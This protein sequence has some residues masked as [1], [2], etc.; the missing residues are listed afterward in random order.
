MPP[1]EIIWVVLTK[2]Q[3]FHAPGEI[4]LKF[5]AVKDRSGYQWCIYAGKKDQLDVDILLVGD[6]VASSDNIKSIMPCDDE[7]FKLYRY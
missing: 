4:T 1:G 2:Y 5:I 7:M 6:K 3:N